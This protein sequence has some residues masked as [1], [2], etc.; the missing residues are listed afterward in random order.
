MN[1]RGR[2]VGMLGRI[3]VVAALVALGATGCASYPYAKNVKMVS[4]DGSVAAGQGIG[5]VRGESCQAFV[6]GYPLGEPPTLDKAIANAREKN[7]LRYMN[8][9]GTEDGGFNAVFYSKTCMIVKGTG[10]Q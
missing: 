3:A 5:P 6:M 4:F 8:N 2:K 9:V 1:T 10:Y 7:K